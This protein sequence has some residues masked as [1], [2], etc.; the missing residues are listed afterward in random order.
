MVLFQEGNGVSGTRTCVGDTSV[1]SSGVLGVGRRG[2]GH[3]IGPRRTFQRLIG[4]IRVSQ[5]NEK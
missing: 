2:K 1:E 4:V 3:L 5:I